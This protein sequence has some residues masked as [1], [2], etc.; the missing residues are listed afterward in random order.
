[1]STLQDSRPEWRRGRLTS[2]FFV[3][4]YETRAEFA[5]LLLQLPLR[6]DPAACLPACLPAGV[7]ASAAAFMCIMKQFVVRLVFSSAAL[8]S[9]FKHLTLPRVQSV[10][11]NPTVQATPSIPT[12]L[13][14]PSDVHLAPRAT[15]WLKDFSSLLCWWNYDKWRA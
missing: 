10:R 1:M 12:F 15:S 11:G 8:L 4:D 13:P 2:A 5:F 9:C 3:S 6:A 14:I 7:T